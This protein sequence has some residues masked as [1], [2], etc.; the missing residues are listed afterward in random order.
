M[1]GGVDSRALWRIVIAEN[2]DD[3]GLALESSGQTEMSP[4]A[5]CRA[6]SIEDLDVLRASLGVSNIPICFTHPGDVDL[7]ILHQTY[8]LRGSYISDSC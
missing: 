4:T 7:S 3:Q 5:H 2:E 8:G 1:N 6:T